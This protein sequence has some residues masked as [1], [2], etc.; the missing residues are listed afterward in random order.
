MFRKKASK[1]ATICLSCATG[2]I[3]YRI[4]FSKPWQMTAADAFLQHLKMFHRWCNSPICT[5]QQKAKEKVAA[6]ILLKFN[7]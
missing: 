2:C 5:K 1:Q 6:I 3:T 4:D 7:E